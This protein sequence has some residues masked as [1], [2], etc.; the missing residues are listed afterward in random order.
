[1]LPTL[2]AVAIDTRPHA[3]RRGA[4]SQHGLWPGTVAARTTWVVAQPSKWS[5]PREA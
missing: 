2:L 3:V 4:S 5:S 1:M